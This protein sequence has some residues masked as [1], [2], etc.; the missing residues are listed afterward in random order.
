MAK[1][2][3]GVSMVSILQEGLQRAQMD[4]FRKVM[5]HREMFIRSEHGTRT[6]WENYELMRRALR[7]CERLRD[8]ELLLR[9]TGEDVGPIM[10]AP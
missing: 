3:T 7:S 2:L 9:G 10:G 1:A 5:L 8:A 4:A 6:E